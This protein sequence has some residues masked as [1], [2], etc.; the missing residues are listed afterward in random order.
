MT[1]SRSRQPVL[2]RALEIAINLA[3]S[4]APPSLITFR[5]E[6]RHLSRMRSFLDA[7]PFFLH[8]PK[9]GG[10]SVQLAIGQEK[11]GHF[12]FD[13]LVREDPTFA[14]KREYFLNTS[15]SN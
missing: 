12:T 6:Q 5:H 2:G 8:V 14:D 9:S 1:T 15:R 10:Q 13:R 3:F 11:A 7:D 4:A